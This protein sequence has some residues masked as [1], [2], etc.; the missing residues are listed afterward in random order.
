[1]RKRALYICTGTGKLGTILPSGI[2]AVPTQCI[3]NS[4]QCICTY[5][6]TSVQIYKSIFKE[7]YVSICKEPYT[8]AKEPNKYAKVRVI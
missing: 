8:C 2:P 5:R 4:T 7:A 1:V 6:Y 3:C